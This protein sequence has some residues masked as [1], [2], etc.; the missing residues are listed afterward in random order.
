MCSKSFAEPIKRC[1]ESSFTYTPLDDADPLE[2][3]PHS[4]LP[5]TTPVN[6]AKQQTPPAADS[7]SPCSPKH[8]AHTHPHH[9]H[10]QRTHLHLLH[11]LLAR[12]H[13]RQLLQVIDVHQV[14]KNCRQ[15]ASSITTLSPGMPPD[16]NAATACS[17]DCL[18]QAPHLSHVHMWYCWKRGALSSSLSILTFS[19]VGRRKHMAC[20]MCRVEQTCSCA[21]RVGEGQQGEPY[22]QRRC[23]VWV[24]LTATSVTPPCTWDHGWQRAWT[25]LG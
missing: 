17:E 14:G 9:S 13:L 10:I 3:I 11:H 5:V 12:V 8:F 25:L 7:G 19:R 24:R 6:K 21:Q 2:S 4:P 18:P 22:G 23:A 20:S 15:A 16:T 1:V